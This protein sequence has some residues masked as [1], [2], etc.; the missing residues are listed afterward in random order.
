MEEDNA[1]N[2]SRHRK[3][4]DIQEED[5]ENDHPPQQQE[6]PKVETTTP[7]TVSSLISTVHQ[8]NNSEIGVICFQRSS[9]MKKK[10]TPLFK[11]HI[12]KI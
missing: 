8:D 4:D 6:P 3:I 7:G 10:R 9:I 1:S 5:E 11:K 2:T 12:L